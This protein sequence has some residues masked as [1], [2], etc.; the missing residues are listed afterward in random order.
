MSKSKK[1]AKNT[2]ML[3][4]RMLFSMFVSL[5]T[6][7]IVLDV[8]G[9]EDYG[10]YNVVGGVVTI[11]SFINSSMSAATQRFLS[12]GLG[13]NNPSHLRKTFNAAL[14]IHFATGVLIILLGE[15]IGMYVLHNYL[16]IP[17][18]RMNIAEIVFQFSLFSTFLMIVRVPFNAAIIANEKMDFYAYISIF[19]VILRLI[20]IF[21]L[22]YITLD[23]LMLYSVLITSIIMV[24]LIIVYWYCRKNFGESK[25]VLVKDKVLYKEL[26]GY[27]GWSLFGNMA[28]VGMS[29]GVNLLLN[30]FFG[31][32]V[33]AAR[34]IS[35]QV[36]GA[37]TAF[38]SNFQVAVNPQIIKSYAS[39]D[40]DYMMKLVFTS[41]RL[42]FFLL[43]F[44]AMPVLLET[45][46]LLSFW[47]NKVPDFAVLFTFLVIINALIDSISGPLMTTANATGNIKWYQ[48]IVGT[49][50]LLNLPISYVFLELNFSPQITFYI[51]IIISLICLNLRL[52]ILKK[53]VNFDIRKFYSDVLWKITIVVIGSTILPIIF[54][55]QFNEGPIRFI[56]VSCVSVI[57]VISFVYSIGTNKK[58]KNMIIDKIQILISKLRKQS[59]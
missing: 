40:R 49:T 4:V 35:Y 2:L 7:R 29:Q 34:A 38:S 56:L 48:I 8:L 6:S 50:L 20:M 55:S 22:M 51:S 43:F 42:T 53:L 30:M 37:I 11:F 19:E 39:E 15:T 57:S 59:S 27:S 3:Y 25:F 10:I 41:S 52:L 14:S 44:L 46:F 12:F 23:K 5:Y 16:T 18:E 9:V 54:L 33:N 47:L 36:S 13:K 26:I 28:S 31:P 21:L 32:A 45:H 17:T 24:N 1:I 58:E